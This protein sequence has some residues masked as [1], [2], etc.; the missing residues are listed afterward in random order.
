[1][2]K[3]ETLFILG[4]GSSYPYGYP[5][6]KELVKHI[7]DNIQNDQ[8]L[9][10]LLKQP[11]RDKYYYNENDGENKN[12]DIIHGYE[13]HDFEES[14]ISQD[15]IKFSMAAS[16]PN[17]ILA[18]QNNY[19]PSKLNQFNEFFR[20][21]EALIKFDPLSIDTFLRDHPSHVKAGKIMI[22][23]SLLKCE[24]KAK[25]AYDK[26]GNDNWYS[27]LLN[28]ILSGCEKPFHI[29]NNK[30][31]IITF[32]YDLSLDYCLQR[33]LMD[34]EF[35]QKDKQAE[36]YIHKLLSH[37]IHHV[38]GKLYEDSVIDIYGHYADNKN[39][40]HPETFNTKRLIKSLQS[41]KSI[42]SI[43]QERQRPSGY[44]KLI[45]DAKE[46]IIIGFGFD[47]DNLNLLSFPRTENAYGDFFKGKT[48][49][50]LDY[51]GKMNGLFSQFDRVQ[52]RFDKISV[53]RSTANQITNAYL[54]DF[55]IFL[56]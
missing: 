37:D 26:T 14:L 53:T 41:H 40:L 3:T 9:I 4:A 28:D 34:T 31:K 15:S 42:R 12:G 7:I 22:V 52:Q 21:R 6:G 39:K 11:L 1:M 23:Y 33:K 5:L 29:K 27:C 35:L 36:K 49:R 48:I 54:N 24:K 13:L 44:E 47:R 51:E 45:K 2:F 25:L 50:Y 8:I 32:N 38:Y 18:G 55:K 16:P 56:Y 19:Y 43:Y 10:P 46:I 17:T 30:L 20:L